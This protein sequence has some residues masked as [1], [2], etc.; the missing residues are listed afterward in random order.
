MRI[1]SIIA[2]ALAAAALASAVSCTPPR[3]K[4][5]EVVIWHQKEGADREL[6]EEAIERFNREHPAEHVTALFRN[7]E[8]LRTSFIIAAVAGQ[9][10]D[11]V[12]GPSDNVA[13][14]AETRVIRS[15]DEVLD[16]EFLDR[17]TPEAVTHWHDRPWLVADQ[18][19]DQL[20]LVYDRQ[21]V[22]QPPQTL[23]ELVADGERL[24]LRSGDR[25]DR[26]GLALDLE[27]PFFFIPFL[28]GFG[29]WIM[30]K[31]DNPTLDTPE[32]RRALQ[33]VLDLRDRHR[34]IPRLDG[35]ETISLAFKR[36]R[37]AMIINGPWSWSGYGVPERSMVAMLPVNTETGLHCRPIFSAKGYC[38]NINT[39]PGKFATVRRV[40]EHLAGHEVQMQMALS[41]Y[42]TPTIKSVIDSPAFRT[43]PVL[44]LALRQSKYSI[45]M[46]ITPK[47]RYIWD[48]IRGPYRRLF[49][50]DL[51]PDEAAREMQT[52]AER[53]IAESMP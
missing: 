32:M 23:D 27:E 22:E 7:G 30:D 52:E 21:T 5:G 48:G 15:W 24:T 1:P 31:D 12:Y 29:G 20:M 51:T 9:G 8:E 13:L 39:R 25:V 18:V 26:Y 44:Q 34:I 4:P 40:L 6:F 46:P 49:A 42:T 3:E 11:L 16:A 10:P 33:F 38:L 53:R 35:Y 43:N 14:F 47:L 19:G 28:T 45:P 37:A 50:G 2:R 17:F 36:R 41:L